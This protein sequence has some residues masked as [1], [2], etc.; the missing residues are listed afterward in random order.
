MG[1]QIPTR[2]EALA[3]LRQYNKNESLIK[4]ALAVEGVMRYMARKH[5]E[6]EEEAADGQGREAAAER[7][8]V[9][10]AEQAK[11]H[12]SPSVEIDGSESPAMRPRAISCYESGSILFQV[13]SQ[14]TGGQMARAY[15]FQDRR[16]LAAAATGDGTP[17]GKG[18]A[19]GG[20]R[21]IRRAFWLWAWGTR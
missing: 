18:T 17:R 5:G 20:R 13:A 14:E 6:D 3:L 11:S 16:F 12:R 9:S 8:C 15:L 19:A 10:V 2:E 1:S 7:I 21:R 4:H